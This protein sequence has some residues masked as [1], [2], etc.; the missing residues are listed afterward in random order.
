MICFRVL[1]NQQNQHEETSHPS[2]GELHMYTHIGMPIIQLVS[3]LEVWY[4]SNVRKLNR[5]SFIYS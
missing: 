1:I 4:S 2:T 3:L 5:F